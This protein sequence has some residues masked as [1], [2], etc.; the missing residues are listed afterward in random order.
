MLSLGD[1]EKC[2]SGNTGLRLVSGVGH[3]LNGLKKQRTGILDFINY[4]W[5][6]NQHRIR[7][8]KI[9]TWASLHVGVGQR[10]AFCSQLEGIPVITLCVL[11][12]AA[13][14]T[15]L[16]GPVAFEKCSVGESWHTCDFQGPKR[17]M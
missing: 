5:K 12:R 4:N 6:V 7:N 11:Q 14:T 1:W 8:F 16:F 9:P 15:V 3:I 13:P 17:E 2:T 10:V